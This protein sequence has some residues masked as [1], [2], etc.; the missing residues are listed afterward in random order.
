MP[1][2]RRNPVPNRTARMPD[3]K[4]QH[5]TART[6]GILCING[7]PVTRQMTDHGMKSHAKLML[8]EDRKYAS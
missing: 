5:Q 3:V 4:M 6:S 7:I 2:S 1:G 8:L